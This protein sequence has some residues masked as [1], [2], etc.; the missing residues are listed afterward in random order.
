MT[1]QLLRCA[2]AAAL[3]LA[4]S[5]CSGS[6]SGDGLGDG[7]LVSNLDWVPID[8]GDE[9]FGP[10]PPD[11]ICILEP[12]GDCP[13]PDGEC[14]NIE[15]G[16]NCVVSFIAECLD[17]FTV[18]SVYTRRPDG[19]VG[20]NWITFEQ[21][22]LTEIRE[23]DSVEVRAFH[24]ALNAPIGAQARIMLSIGDELVFE[25]TVLIPRDF[26]FYDDIWIATRDFPAGTPVRFHI[27]NH[28]TNEYGL[29]E[30]NVIR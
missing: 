22:S 4:V 29:V 20:C 8:S 16:S 9:I 2:L 25:Q 21:P 30:V 17:Q 6:D 24:F 15:P 13:V 12:E 10:P 1:E 19:T 23:G 14:V 28:G 26:Q 7:A 3:T 11:A 18:L 27:D 5:S